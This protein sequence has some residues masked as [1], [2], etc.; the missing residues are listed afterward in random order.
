VVACGVRRLV[1]RVWAF[2]MEMGA[3]AQVQRERRELLRPDD[4]M[5]PMYSYVVGGIHL[6]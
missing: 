2:R 6:G 1:T 4:G 5:G 3:V